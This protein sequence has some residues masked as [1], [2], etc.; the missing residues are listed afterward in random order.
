MKYPTENEVQS[1]SHIQLAKWWRF[2]SSPGVS[3]F[4]SANF[5]EVLEAEVDI[6]NSIG[7][8]L[9]TLGGI[10]PEISK[11]IGWKNENS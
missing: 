1:A 11:Q 5:E 7:D 2:L 4:D 6:M 3:A 9:E 10:T 8:R